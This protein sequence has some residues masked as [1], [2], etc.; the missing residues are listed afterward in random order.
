MNTALESKIT[1]ESLRKAYADH[2]F[3]LFE[4]DAV[5]LNLNIFGVRSKVYDTNTFN[6]IVGLAWKYGGAWTL[7]L[8]SATTDPGLYYFANPMTSKGTHIMKEG[9]YR[10][11]YAAGKHQGKYGALIQVGPMDFYADNDR[12]LVFDK[13]V[14]EKG[15]YIGA[16]VH[17]VI[18][19]RIP[20][21]LTA[22]VSDFPDRESAVVHNWSA[23]CQVLANP[24]KYLEFMTYVYASAKAFGNKFTYTLFE[25]DAF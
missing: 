23:A 25:E 16:N 4:K 6:D 2:G 7:K 11:A 12:D 20:D 22:P 3:V 19:K 18:N 1:I 14:V 15:V 9:Q 21:L 8:Y 13:T 5:D 10:G 24:R 17:C